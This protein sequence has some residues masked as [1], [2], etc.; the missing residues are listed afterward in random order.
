MSSAKHVFRN[1]AATVAVIA[2]AL[3][4]TPAFAKQANI[5]AATSGSGA[6]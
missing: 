4:A 1:T 2:A 6:T 3:A 5:K